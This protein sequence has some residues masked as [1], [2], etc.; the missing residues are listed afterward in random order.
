MRLQ[1]YHDAILSREKVY[2]TSIFLEWQV[3][4]TLYNLKLSFDV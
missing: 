4:K 1:L 2:H 3:F